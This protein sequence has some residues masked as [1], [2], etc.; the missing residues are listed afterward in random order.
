MEILEINTD[1][2][3][4]KAAE[5]RLRELN[6]ELEQ[7]VIERTTEL[8]SS[9][10][11]LREEIERRKA[12]EEQ[13]LQSQKMEAIGQLAGGVAHDFNNLLTIIVG[14]GRLLQEALT[15]DGQ[16]QERMTQL[17]GAA[18]RAAGLVNQLLAFSRRQIA[19]PRPLNLNAIVAKAEMMLH[20]ILGEEIQ[21]VTTLSPELVNTKVDP[22][23]I[24][25]VLLNLIINAKDAMPSGGRITIETGNIEFDAGYAG[26][27][28]GRY[29]MLSVSDTGIGMD[30]A[31]QSR[32]FEPFFTTKGPGKGTGL[33]LSTVYG[34]VK[35]NRGEISVQS[36][37]GLGSTFRVCLPEFSEVPELAEPAEPRARA[38][39]GTETILL[40]ED[41]TDVRKLARD[42]LT[43]Q[44]Y[45]VLECAGGKEALDCCANYRGPINLVLTDV[46]MPGMTGGQL[47]ENLRQRYPTIKVLY[48]TGYAEDDVVHHGLID[49]MLAL[50]HKPFTPRALTEKVR[51]MLDAQQGLYRSP[52]A[53]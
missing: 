47:G 43:G 45:T 48:M 18:D 38:I 49:P 33:G 41:E 37:P 35:Q 42:I 36:V 44:G 26:L 29:V 27:P 14:H 51:Q 39:R 1:I 22:V 23:Q 6:Q 20:R 25:Q 16:E 12:L 3:Q 46:V 53:R 28:P 9:N 31:L 24:E 30:A 34:I 21:L 10:E 17:L 8:R 15:P 32:I 19:Q 7:R 40:V 52:G 11:Q 13:L 50:V 2:S 4:Q 5:D